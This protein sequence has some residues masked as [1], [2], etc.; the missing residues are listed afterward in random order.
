MTDYRV[1]IKV[2]NARL[3]RAIE[4]AGHQPGQ[5][6]AREV[7]ISYTGHLLPYLNLKRTPFDEI[8]DLRP[9]AEMLCVFLN[10]LP[11][12]LW[13][14]EQRYPLLTNAAEIELSAASVHELLASHSDC[15]D[16]LSLLEKKQAAQ[17]VDALAV[18][19]VD[20]DLALAE[21]LVQHAAFGQRDLVHR[22]VGHV[23]R[24]ALALAVVEAAFDFVHFAVQGAAVQH[25]EFLHATA[26]AEEGNATLDAGAHQAQ[27]GGVAGFVSQTEAGMVVAVEAGVHVGQRAAEHDAGDAV[28][29][30]VH[31]QVVGEGRDHQREGAVAGD[32]LDVFLAHQVEPADVAVSQLPAAQGETNHGFAHFKGVLFC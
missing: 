1:Q 13:S 3:L 12:E 28:E 30:G 18:Q 9:C 20:A 29:H 8:G 17:A 27:H 23:V 26:D 32:G 19:R 21:Q 4:K 22:A 10:R 15:A 2:R 11:D 6:F 24:H 5:I 25:V 14:E 7:G 16:P 31:V